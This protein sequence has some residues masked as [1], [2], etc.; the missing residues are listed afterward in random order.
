M[1]IKQIHEN[2]SNYPP[3]LKKYLANNA[4]EMLTAIG[5]LDIL[6]N[7]ALAIFSSVKCPGSHILKTY[8]F[9]RQLRG[10][11][12]TVISGFHSPIEKECLRL[13]LKGNA[14]VIVC[15]ARGIKNM[16]I[17]TEWKKIINEGRMLILSP[18]SQNIKRASVK[19]SI[20]RNQFILS[21]ADKI[22][23][24]Y[25]EPGSKTEMLCKEWIK[26]GKMVRT[27]DSDYN[28]NLFEL[29]AEAIG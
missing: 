22:F 25:A 8:D 4:P 29:G 12:V 16:H 21:L 11:D 6:Q 13:L 9:M 1:N 27:F 15:P 28:K 20:E 18:F 2:D 23:V 10:T 5:N 7:K 14:P 17:P 24:S 26:Q 3:A 19:S